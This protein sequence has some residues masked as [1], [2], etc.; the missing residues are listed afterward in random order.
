[1]QQGTSQD[2]VLRPAD[3]YIA[4]FVKDVNRRRVVHVE[5]VMS[6]YDPDVGIAGP[7][8]APGTTLDDAMRLLAGS[9]RSDATVVFEAGAP[10]GVVDLCQLASAMVSPQ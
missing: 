10:I 1:M 5:A 6:P 9:P 4:D 3:D 7:T 2:I 8:V